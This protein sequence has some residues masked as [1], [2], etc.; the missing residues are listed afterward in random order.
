MP[1]TTSAQLQRQAGHLFHL[2][3]LGAHCPSASRTCRKS[4]SAR[5]TAPATAAYVVNYQKEKAA[6][7]ASGLNGPSSSIFITRNQTILLPP[8]RGARAHGGEPGRVAVQPVEPAR[9][10]SRQREPRRFGGVGVCAEL[11]L[12]LLSAATDCAADVAYSGGAAPGPRQRW[13]ASR[14]MRPLVPLPGAEPRYVDATGNY[15]GAPL[16]FDRPVKA[17][18]SADGS[19]AYVLNCGPECGGTA[20][21]DSLLPVAPMIFPGPAIG[22]LPCNA[23]HARTPRLL[24]RQ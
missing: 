22:M 4:R 2:R 24:A 7:S 17:V 16:V 6:G 10:L 15:Y 14:R 13:I 23:A 9:R 1:S 20:S 21:S 19:T 18:F 3:L 8:T 5:S 11:E 12:R